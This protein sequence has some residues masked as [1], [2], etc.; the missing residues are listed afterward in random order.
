MIRM[1]VGAILFTSGLGWFNP[2]GASCRPASP[3]LH[4]LLIS[5][6][7]WQGRDVVHI[8]TFSYVSGTTTTV[9]RALSFLFV[10]PVQDG[11]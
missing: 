2:P 8:H 6:V 4:D 10:S 11:P 9:C 7:L 5:F 3:G 1:M